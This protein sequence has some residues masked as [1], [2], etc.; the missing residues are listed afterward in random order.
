M[1]NFFSSCSPSVIWTIAK[2]D[3]KS[4]FASPKGY[5]IFFFFLLFLGIF[6]HNFMATFVELQQRA[7]MTGGQ[8]PGLDQLLKALFYNLHFIL[9]LII[10]AVTMSS[11][12][13]EKKNQSFRLLLNAPISPFQ[14]V[15]GKYLAVLLCMLAALLC[16]TVF[17]L[18][19]GIYGNPDFGI[20]VSSYL[21]IFLL[22]SA[23]ISLGIWISSMTQNQFIAFLFT[24]CG[25]FLLLILN[26]L[27]RDIAQGGSFERFLKYLASTEHLDIFL[28]GMITVSDITYFVCFTA[29]FL[30]FTTVIIDSQRWR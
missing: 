15:M 22:I 9:I 17:P 1:A 11:F 27:A 2:R 25:L 6:F 10:P 12:S 8:A 30:F 26:W 7:P 28:K 5:A 14:I 3:L 21:G 13:E 20:I 18:F 24:M 16:S 19:I 29:I 23:Q 4:T